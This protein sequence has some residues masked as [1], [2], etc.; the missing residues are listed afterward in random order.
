MS[1]SHYVFST[2]A[3][4]MT[5]VH[6]VIPGEGIPPVEAGS[7]FIQGGAGV[8]QRPK[9]G[10]DIW[11]PLGRMTTVTDEQLE[12][13][14]QNSVFKQHR[15][16]GFITV[17]KK[18]IDVEKAVADMNRKDNS[19]PKVEADFPGFIVTTEV[20]KSADAHRI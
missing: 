9:P 5:Y 15:E 13:L 1:G 6:W 2:L 4:D 7:V 10:S 16:N 17:Q 8:A 14:E 12:I 18:A 19:S 3:T 11:T 20:P